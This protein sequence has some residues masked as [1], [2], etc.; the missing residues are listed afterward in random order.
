MLYIAYV[1]VHVQYIHT[2]GYGLKNL[3]EMTSYINYVSA[4]QFSL[5]I[6]KHKNYAFY[7]VLTDVR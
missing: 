1:L 4:S 2:Y 5:Q 3:N 6:I 7:M